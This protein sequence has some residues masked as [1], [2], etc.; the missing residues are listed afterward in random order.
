MDHIEYI[1]MKSS[2]DLFSLWYHCSLFC[3]SS[4]APLLK[5]ILTN[6]VDAVHAGPLLKM[7]M[8]TIG[9]HF[10]SHVQVIWPWIHW[11]SLI[12]SLAGVGAF[13]FEGQTVQV[14]TS[15]EN[16]Q[17][18]VIHD[19]YGHA[20]VT[21]QAGSSGWNARWPVCLVC[22]LVS[23]HIYYLLCSWALG[24]HFLSFS[25]LICTYMITWPRLTWLLTCTTELSCQELHCSLL[26]YVSHCSLLMVVCDHHCLWPHC[27]VTLIVCDSIVLPFCTLSQV[28]ALLYISWTY[29]LELGLKPD[30]VCNLL[31]S[32][33][34]LLEQTI[35]FFY[36]LGIIFKSLKTI[37]IPLF[38]HPDIGLSDPLAFITFQST[39]VY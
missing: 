16:T 25:C 18:G 32:L 9:I 4:S 19:S 20:T 28:A 33:S 1:W 21:K 7:P 6:H 3:S 5:A 36:F 2:C 13:D 31:H 12:V 15:L 26:F 23:H 24:P 38:L 27:S 34:L 10:R 22:R 14:S 30:L 35:S 29:I 8:Y 39:L 17:D 37:P 11:L